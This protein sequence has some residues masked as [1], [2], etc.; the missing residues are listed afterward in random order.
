MFFRV[1]IIGFLQA[2]TVFSAATA[3]S[4]VQRDSSC[5]TPDN[6][7]CWTDGFNITT[8]WEKEVPFTGR[9]VNYTL[10]LE[11]YDIIGPDGVLK[12]DAM[13]FND[14]G[15]WVNVTIINKLLYN[16]TSIHWH[17]LQMEDN[18]INDG[19]GGVT[20][21]P[22]PP[23]ATKSYLF[24]AEQYGTTWYHSHYSSQY[25]NGVL[26]AIV[27]NGPASANYDVD[28]GTF[29]INDW[30]YESTDQIL[31]QVQAPGEHGGPTIPPPPDNILFNGTNVNPAD[32]TM[33]EYARVVLTP[34]LKYRLRLFNPSVNYA[35]TFS[36]V[37]HNFTVIATDLV[38]VNTTDPSTTV[39]S[40]FIAVG[41]R[42][43]IIIQGKSEEEI[44]SDPGNGNYWIN[45]TQ[46]ISGYCGNFY[47]KPA[48]ILSYDYPDATDELPIID[49]PVPEDLRCEDTTDFRPVVVR[50]VPPS[51][52]SISP[53]NTLPVHLMR[54][55]K[56][57]KVF[58]T[59]DNVA[60]NV[61]WEQPLLEYI[62]EDSTSWPYS[63]NVLEIPPESEWSFWLIENESKIPHPMHL[64]G[65]DFI[66][67]GRSPAPDGPGPS[68]AMMPARH[69]DPVLD[70]SSLNFT[71]PARRDVTMLPGNGWLIVAFQN[72]N[73]GAWLFHCHIA[74][75]V[76]MGLSVQFLERKNE[77]KEKMDLNSLV[78]N[79]NAWQS[80]IDTNPLYQPK[81]DSGV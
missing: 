14:W 13:L 50:D 78:D 37:G 7:A 21:C 41:Q 25:G 77:I 18:N 58:W 32:I 35:Y 46:P 11:Q 44:A 47:G 53:Y 64:H 34:G 19:V 38:P 71:N 62:R 57:S 4:L 81:S 24:L 31:A 26:G 60:I 8:D 29:P 20:E 59:I 74:W 27:F 42:F 66:I 28:L 61:S 17:G 73:P 43:D 40:L 3:S 79:C 52:F 1:S 54:D 67:V 33:G 51:E 56:Q 16:G 63:E 12:H 76:S 69:F 9:T 80:Y 65:H 55:M 10:V 22:I 36:I 5:N 68:D 70:T 30:Y 45:A 39:S 48:A 72:N 75:H 49:G 15:D 6:R 2:L 23:N